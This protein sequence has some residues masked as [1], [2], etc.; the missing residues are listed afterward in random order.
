MVTKVRP[1]RGADNLAAIYGRLSRQCVIL[2]ISQPYMPPRPVTAIA[3]LQFY[4]FTLLLLLVFYRHYYMPADVHY[5]RNNTDL[6]VHPKRD[7]QMS[8]YNYATLC[9]FI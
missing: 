9:R 8:E 5:L 1:V 7:R 2:N 4:F 6:T 3:L